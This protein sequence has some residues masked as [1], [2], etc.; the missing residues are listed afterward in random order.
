MPRSCRRSKS[1]LPFT[2]RIARKL[3][4]AGATACRSHSVFQS[5]CRGSSRTSNACVMP[6]RCWRAFWRKPVNWAASLAA[7]WCNCL[8]ACH[9]T[10]PAP[11]HFS[12]ALRERTDT[13]VV[14][15]ARHRSWFSAQAAGV[16]AELGI[17]QV[18]ADPEVAPVA[19][20]FAGSS[21]TVYIR[22]H[23]SPQIYH[24]PYP[25]NFL[26][27]LAGE[28]RQYRAQGKTAWCVFDNTASGAAMPNALSLLARFDAR[29]APRP[30]ESA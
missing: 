2:G 16:L 9:S 13:P 3:T 20:P 19:P 12:S 7:C 6:I 26:D 24:S 10:R 29:R 4:G 22:L 25:E 17:S 15:E 18:I 14:C 30:M 11:R 21:G 28:L 27:Q 8:P 1:T 23:G 5:S